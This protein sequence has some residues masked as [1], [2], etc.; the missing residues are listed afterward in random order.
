MKLHIRQDAIELG[1]QIDS[2]THNF[3]K[4][5]HY[6]VSSQIRRAID[7]VAMNISEGSIIQSRPEFRKFLG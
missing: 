6:K 5:E 2:L 7:S 3:P 4:K 1:E